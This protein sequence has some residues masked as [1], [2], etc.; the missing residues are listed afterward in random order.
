MYS[1]RNAYKVLVPKSGTFLFLVHPV[2]VKVCGRSP[3]P[4]VLRDVVK[5]GVGEGPE[6]RVG[7]VVVARL[8]G[9]SGTVGHLQQHLKGFNLISNPI[10]NNLLT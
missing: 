10:S 7:R 4:L 6:G 9:G 8:Q 5:A 3:L 2:V 1:I